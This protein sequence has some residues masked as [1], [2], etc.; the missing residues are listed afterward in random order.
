M[1]VSV[2]RPVPCFGVGGAPCVCCLV[3]WWVHAAEGLLEQ[4]YRHHQ[5]QQQQQQQQHYQK[6]GWC[7]ASPFSP[8]TLPLACLRRVSRWPSL[9][10]PADKV[11]RS[12]SFGMS[13]VPVRTP[14]SSWASLAR[15]SSLCFCCWLTLPPALPPFFLPLSHARS[16][17][18]GVFR[19]GA[20]IPP[21][22]GAG[23]DAA[24]GVTK[25][26]LDKKVGVSF[27]FFSSLISPAQ[28]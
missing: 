2:C 23:N 25:L 21:A 5:Q 6:D 26:S 3:C 22:A 8:E 13:C 17:V 11:C 16:A 28:F 24:A 10:S 14:P 1:C 20:R 9:V 19:D 12:F 18:A 15:E 27:F 7:H 4:R